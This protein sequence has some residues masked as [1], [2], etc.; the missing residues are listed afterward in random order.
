MRLSGRFRHPLLY[1]TIE[2]V[3]LVKQLEQ[4]GSLL[5]LTHISFAYCMLYDRLGC[6]MARPRGGGR[7]GGRAPV[8]W[9]EIEMEPDNEETLPPPPPVVGEANGGGAGPQGGVGPQAGAGPQAGQGP[10]VGDLSPLIQAI[11]EAFQTAMAGV[12]GAAQPQGGGNG[13]PLERLRHLGGDEFR[14]L[15]PEKS[16]A[17][18]ES[19]IRVLGQMECTDARKLGCVVSLLQ[20]DAYAWWTTVISSMDEDDITWGFF[21]SAFRKKYLGSRYEDEKKREFMA[22]VQGSMSVTD[23][24]I[25]FVRL[26]HGSSSGKRPA[27]WDR[28]STKRHKDQRF[29]PEPRR[30]GGN[31]RRGHQGQ[32]RFQQ[33]PECARCGRRHMGECWGNGSSCWNCGARGHMRRD[34]PHPARRNVAH[35]VAVQPEGGGP[36]RVYAQHEG[37]NDTNMI[38]GNFS[39][40]S[41]SL[42]SLIDSGSTHS[43]ILSEHAR[44][45]DVPCEVLD[46]GVNVT[47]S[48]GDTIV[49]RKL[50]RRCP[51][52]IQGYVFPVDMMELPFY[53]F[54]VILGMDWLV[55]H[56]VR[57]DF[58]TKRVSL[59]FADDHEIVVVG[60]N[61]KF[62]SNVVSV[63]EAQRLMDC[64]CQAY[65]AYV[66]NPNMGEARPRDI[67]T[68]CDFSGVFPEELPGLP[69]DREVEFV[70]ET[71]ADSAPVSISPYRMAPKELKELKTQLQ[72]LLDRGFIRPSTSPWGAPVLFVKKKDESLRMCIDYRQLN[73]MTVKNKYPLPRIDDLFDQLRG[74]SVFSKIDLRS[75]YY[76]LKVREQDVLKTAFRT[77]YGH[78]EFLVMPFG[79]TNAPA[80]FMDL[81]N[82]VFHEYL[83]QFVVVFIDDILVYSRTEEDHDR[84]LR[85]VLQTLLEN[86]LYAKLS[87]CE[88]WI[89][90]VVF[91]GHVVSSEGIWVDPKKV[92]AIV[93]WK[94]PTSVIEIHS[95]LG[96]AGY[97]R[98]FVSGFSKVAAPLT[99]LLQKGVKYE[100]SDARK[101]AFKKL[102]EALINAP[103]LTQ[104]VSGK[105][106]VVYSDAS[107]VGLGCVLMQEGRVVA[108]ALIACVEMTKGMSRIETTGPALVEISAGIQISTERLAMLLAYV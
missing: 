7:R 89:R 72:E 70:I 3:V 12:Q 17:W 75:G 58:E 74:A 71:H 11:A 47:S 90:E 19:T 30:G 104:P 99:K 36:A 63:L 34:C 22:L 108:Y 43:Y 31:P 56:R 78:Y 35:V 2:N 27:S 103:V 88:F 91:L 81:M 6:G 51:L 1:T 95:F 50:Y 44:L 82:R 107:Y 87:K 41:L 92:E 49:V 5:L 97:Y 67:R 100:W 86:Q 48:F 54:D 13:L 23:Y 25:Q 61:I 46:V 69:P 37:R 8:H 93:N 20:G 66:M 106:F 101:Q 60:E 59:K 24:E 105:E 53:G 15:S 4:I 32:G 14:G 94:Q 84:H 18:L 45:L 68:V 40:Q 98:R 62:L 16:E 83:D 55:E 29:Q 65:L 28:D 85:L 73:K 64:G 96:L 76:Q 10:T 52:M 21:Q 26:S 77:R 38:A 57:V 9:D 42:L 33:A 80:A 39:L 102:K 79:L